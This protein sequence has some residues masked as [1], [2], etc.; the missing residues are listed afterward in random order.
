MK[1]RFMLWMK[2][3]YTYFHLMLAFGVFL[4]WL[5]TSL[6]QPI[7]WIVVAVLLL[8]AAWQLWQS[9]FR[10]S[11]HEVWLS[12][13]A[14]LFYFFIA[15]YISPQVIDYYSRINSSDVVGYIN[16][17]QQI[18]QMALHDPREVLNQ[19][20]IT[21][22]LSTAA[23]YWVV[24]LFS[25]L[26]GGSPLGIL[27]VCAW[28]GVM[29]GFY[30][31]KAFRLHPTEVPPVWYG[32]LV[33]FF[34]SI[35]FWLT[36][37]LKDVIT[38]WAL[39]LM[40]YGASIFVKGYWSN[41]LARIVL[42]TI[43]CFSIRPYFAAFFS[44]PLIGMGLMF[45]TRSFLKRSPYMLISALI[46]VL[47]GSLWLIWTID[48]RGFTI[49]GSVEALD[50][51]QQI[52][53]GTTGGSSISSSSIPLPNA[54]L[55]NAGYVSY[56][57]TRLWY[58]FTVLFRPLPWEAYNIFTFLASLENLALLALAILAIWK[59][60]IVVKSLV[61][62][63]LLLFAAAFAILFIGAFSLQVVNLGGMVRVK[64]NVLP[65]L[66]PFVAIALSEV[67]PKTLY[68]RIFGGADICAML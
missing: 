8:A 25:L 24:G 14:M 2:S 47:V 19:F 38:F 63:P 43:V 41:G 60:Q 50:S 1:E 58:V 56:F 66:F 17:G 48:S 64:I 39:G 16:R 33:L 18:S 55:S 51:Y 5:M 45:L 32:P 12:L 13:L 31:V 57:L 20:V 30:F 68:Q 34:P 4:G 67:L 11:R 21:A 22:N 29:G 15:L 59:S 52:A 26:A 23:F 37:P 10:H 7:N 62:S 54:M 61:R 42:S 3:D 44:V 49:L 35:V 6:L 46:L 40:V 53:G 9:P 36:S 65:F 28:F 27:V